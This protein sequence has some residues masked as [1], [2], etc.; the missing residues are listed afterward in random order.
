MQPL[1]LGLITAVVF[2]GV[3]LTGS[4]VYW[5]W[6]ARRESRAQ[7]LA[8]RLGTLGGDPD[9]TDIFHLKEPDALADALG[10][11]GRHLSALV[12]QADVRYS[13]RGLAARM[14]IAALTGS[15]V[16]AIFLGGPGIVLGLL[17][18]TVPYLWIRRRA[19]KRRI[20]IS[21]QLPDAL[22]LISRSLQAGHGIADAFRLCAEES[23]MPIARELGEVYEQHNLGRDFRE[24][25]TDLAARNPHNFDMKI[26]VS[27]V[28]LQRETGGNLIEILDN[29]A[30][31]VRARFV[32]QA[33]VKALTAEARMSA[34]ILG[35]LPFVVSGAIVVLRPN[36]LGVLIDD[37]LGRNMLI[38]VGSLYIAGAFMMRGLAR[39]EA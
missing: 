6:A 20:A 35:M 7:S 15:V 33:K 5:T 12:R 10:F 39:V 1:I 38:V 32:F 21:E 28:L 30:A 4:F 11:V 29:I 18:G 2:V 27:S 8:L 22:D 13:V 25:M 16:L 3:L 14:G 24:C 19:R 23:P 34:I 37:A 17:F 26:F 36:Y 9:S 31:T